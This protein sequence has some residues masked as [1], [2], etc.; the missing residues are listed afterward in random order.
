[1]EPAAKLTAEAIKNDCAAFVGAL[2]ADSECLADMFFHLRN[3]LLFYLFRAVFGGRYLCRIKPRPLRQFTPHG[4][5][6]RLSF[7]GG[8]ITVITPLTVSPSIAQRRLVRAAA[9]AQLIILTGEADNVRIIAL[10]K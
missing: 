8:T 2:S 10:V 4:N 6:E 5:A 7:Y 3:C 9:R 1:M